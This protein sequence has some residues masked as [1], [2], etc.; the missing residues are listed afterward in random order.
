MR[1]DFEE[2]RS[3]SR[4][5]RSF[6]YLKKARLIVLFTIMFLTGL[7]IM[8]AASIPFKSANDLFIR[9]RPHI[10]EVTETKK[11]R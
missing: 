5:N 2:L 10:K 9:E 3:F 4:N 7:R 1:K 8:E 11:E 6:T